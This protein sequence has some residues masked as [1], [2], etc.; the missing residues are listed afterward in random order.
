MVII[1]GESGFVVI[2]QGECG[3]VVI[4]RG[5]GGFVV[6][7]QLVHA[8]LVELTTLHGGRIFARPALYV[9]QC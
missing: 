1:R 5:E 3:F 8:T 7:F 2:I 9:M 4:I 6:V